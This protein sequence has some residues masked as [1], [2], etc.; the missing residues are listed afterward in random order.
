MI[1][2]HRLD[3]RDQSQIFIA[4]LDADR[5]GEFGSLSDRTQ[6][7]V[8]GPP[9]REIVTRQL[10]FELDLDVRPSSLV[11]AW[12]FVSSVEVEGL[13]SYRFFSFASFRGMYSA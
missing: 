13:R 10:I 11:L 2:R 6:A 1:L 12:S 5:L 8:N 3:H 9:H 4:Q 7:I